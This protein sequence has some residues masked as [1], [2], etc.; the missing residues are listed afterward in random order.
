MRD[1]CSRHLLFVSYVEQYFFR[2]C[3]P[4]CCKD[5]TIFSKNFPSPT[6]PLLSETDPY[7]TSP[8]TYPPPDRRKVYS[9][10]I[11]LLLAHV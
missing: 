9:P 4:L 5:G 1:N 7:P 8:K 11:V 6:T 2:E 3:L 10:P